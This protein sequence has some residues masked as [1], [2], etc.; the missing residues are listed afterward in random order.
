MSTLAPQFWFP[1]RELKNIQMVLTR[2]QSNNQQVQEDD[3]ISDDNLN[4]L[5]SSLQTHN[6]ILNQANNLSQ[7]HNHNQQN[8]ESATRDTMGDRN[9]NSTKFILP[10]TPEEFTKKIQLWETVCQLEQVSEEKKK[11]NIVISNH[12]FKSL[13]TDR[14]TTHCK[15]NRIIWFT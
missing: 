12:Q 9:L 13:L 7:N 6:N 5:M 10:V 11:S 14:T 1:L 4:R 3:L 15:C 2:S 8:S